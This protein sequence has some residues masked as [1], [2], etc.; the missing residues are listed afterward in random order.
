VSYLIY[1]RKSRADAEAEARGEGETLARHKKALLELAGRT[2]LPVGDIYQEIVSGESIAARPQMQKLLSEVEEGR[3]DGVLV[4]EVDRLAR[5]DSIDQGIVAQAFKVSSTKIV[6]PTKTYDPNNEFDEEYFE[7]GLFMSRREYKTIN[8]RLQ[9]GR[10]ASVK[11]GKYLSPKAP[12]GYRRKKLENDKGWTL[13]PVPEQAD[14]VRLIFD[15]YVNG[16]VLP[17]GTSRRLGFYSLAKRLNDLRISPLTASGWV[18][19]TVRDIL[20]NPVHIGKVRWGFRPYEYKVVNGE[21]VK[22][23]RGYNE[24][25]ILAEGLHPPIVDRDVFERAQQ[26]LADAPL[27]PIGHNKKL[28]NPLAGILVCGKCGHKMTYRQVDRGRVNMYCLN[29]GCDNVSAPYH[30]IEERLLS[31]LEQK[32][33]EYRLHLSMSSSVSSARSVD[34]L[35]KALEKIDGEIATLSKQLSTSHDLLEQGIYTP[36]VFLSRSQSLNER[37]NAARSDR[38]RLERELSDQSSFYA[39][40]AETLP[41]IERLLDVYHTLES[42]FAKNAVLKEVLCEATYT[43]MGADAP[44]A[45]TLQLH[46]NLPMSL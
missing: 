42:P 23:R 11:E 7:F 14:V 43:K 6:T 31:G 33:S 18:S 13:E 21:K 3:W 26:L 40:A 22:R 5:G 29:P 16:E 41:K 38:S 10:E 15:L 35:R 32:L 37:I 2:N 12:Y 19:P 30:Y 8:R 20:A 17:D 44:D 9:R 34:H 28:V 39:V 4:M 27:T 25:C 45:F 36:D 24:D 1:L 46:L